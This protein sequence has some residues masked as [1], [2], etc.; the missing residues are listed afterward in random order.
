MR[1]LINPIMRSS[2]TAT[3]NLHGAQTL[4]SISRRDFELMQSKTRPLSSHSKSSDGKRFA[5]IH[6]CEKSG[7]SI[8]TA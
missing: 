3:A 2:S 8:A 4:S 7:H 1:L 5:V 6:F